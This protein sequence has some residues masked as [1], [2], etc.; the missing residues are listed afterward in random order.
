MALSTRRLLDC[1]VSRDQLDEG[2][3]AMVDR[4]ASDAVPPA[5]IRDVLDVAAHVVLG[6]R[7][8]Q[9]SLALICL[10]GGYD[11]C[12]VGNRRVWGWRGGSGRGGRRGWSWVLAG[13]CLRSLRCP[14]GM[15]TR[16]GV[17]AMSTGHELGRAEWPMAP[18]YGDQH[19]MRHR[20]AWRGVGR[21][22]TCPTGHG[23][24]NRNRSGVLCALSPPRASDGG[25]G[26]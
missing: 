8:G 26:L 2:A 21:S 25:L 1:H 4:E 23:H 19:D 11:A 13:W 22:T 9:Q 5:L 17:A 16:A 12:K 14:L 24:R 6:Y 3:G 7:G 10:R 20:G 15:N 18:M